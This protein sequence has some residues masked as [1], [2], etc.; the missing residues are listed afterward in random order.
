MNEDKNA[1]HTYLKIQE[2]AE[3]SFKIKIFEATKRFEKTSNWMIAGTAYALFSCFLSLRE[4]K[5]IYPSLILKIFIICLVLSLLCGVIYIIVMHLYK[6]R[7]SSLIETLNSNE[8]HADKYN[9]HSEKL[10]GFADKGGIARKEHYIKIAF[11]E[12]FNNLLF[13][14]LQL[15]FFL[16]AFFAVTLGAFYFL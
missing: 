15:F 10:K 2:I 7:K 12:A 3:R 9:R 14:L 11:V 5:Q 8:H 13:F 6:V 1:E 16:L 4:L